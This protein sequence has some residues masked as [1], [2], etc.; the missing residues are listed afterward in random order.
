MFTFLMRMKSKENMQELV[1]MLR[2]VFLRKLEWNKLVKFSLHAFY[3]HN[4]DVNELSALCVMRWCCDMN[5]VD[6]P[7]Y[8]HMGSL[9]SFKANARLFGV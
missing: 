2:K 7:L 1:R 6:R 3:I 5:A 8:L 9:W 4:L